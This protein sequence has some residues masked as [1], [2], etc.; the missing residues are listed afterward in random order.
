MGNK[1]MIS[2]P[3]LLSVTSQNVTRATAKESTVKAVLLT[4]RISL[5]SSP[6]SECTLAGSSIS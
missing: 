5:L 4:E 3:L 1:R 6:A 2:I